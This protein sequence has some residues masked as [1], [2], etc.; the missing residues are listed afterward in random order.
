MVSLSLG[1]KKFWTDSRKLQSWLNRFQSMTKIIAIPGLLSDA[2]VFSGI[3]TALPQFEWFDFVR[4]DP[5]SLTRWGQ[6][7]LSVT[8]GPVVLFGHSMGAR[9][10]LESWAFDR[11]RI[12]GMIL[13]DFAVDG[14][15]TE[16][17]RDGRAQRVK[18]AYERGMH[19]L[20]DSWLLPMVAE[21][22]DGNERFR[23][24]EDMVLN[25]T[26]NSHEQQIQALLNR[27]NA[28]TYLKEIRCPTLLL[29]GEED[30]WSP[31]GLHVEIADK[32]TGS[33]LEVVKRAGHFLPFE[34]PDIV[35]TLIDDWIEQ[36]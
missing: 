26:P 11:S 14:T 21:G 17:E 2:R 7:V 30:R 23:E 16:K 27:P 36:T 31:P 24:L 15:V 25:E 6:E 8:G 20:L 3:K 18:G 9:I 10:A 1:A 19:S 22:F 32:V 28:E 33:Q 12:A 35:A 4:S 5:G 29:V 34:C 13:A